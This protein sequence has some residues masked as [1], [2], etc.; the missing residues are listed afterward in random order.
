MPE[1]PPPLTGDRVGPYR[2]DGVLGVGGM[3]TVWRAVDENG[4]AVAL[5][6]LHPGRT[7][8]DEERRFKREFMTLRELRHPGVVAVFGAG[9][10]GLYPWL[11][12]E[13]VEGTD[14]D[15]LLSRWAETAPP[16]RF[17]RARALLRGLCEALDYVHQRGLIHRDIKPS[18]VLLDR[19]GRPKLTDFGVVKA[20]GGQFSTELTQVG[21]LVGTVAFMAPEQISGAPV[22]G[23][24]DLYSLGAVLYLLLTGRRPIEAETIAGYLSRHLTE[25]P[26]S[27]AELDPRVPRRLD[28]LCMRLLRK[29]PAQR[30]AS[31]RQVL[32]ALDGEEDSAPAALFGRQAELAA[33]MARLGRLRQGEGGLLLLRGPTGSGRTALLQTL[34][35]D[36]RRAGF[37]VSMANGGDRALL[38][39]L[40][41]QLPALGAAARG[42][43]AR[44]RLA[45]RSSG[46][47]WAL[48]IDDLDHVDQANLDELTLLVRLQLAIG[49]EPLLVIAALSD[50][51][52]RIARLCSGADTGVS[53]EHHPVN[54]LD[55]KACVAL[56]RAA[57]VSGQAAPALGHRLA[58]ERS[59]LPGAILEQ[60]ELLVRQG[61]L[62]RGPDG[63]LRAGRPLD[64]LRDEPL[65]LPER[66]R[67]G[68]AARLAQL[69][70]GARAVL[71]ALVVI[72]LPVDLPL[73]HEIARLPLAEVERGAQDLIAAALAERVTEEGQELLRLR[74]DRPRDLLYSLIPSGLHEALHRA[75]GEALLRRARRRPGPLGAVIARHLLRAG[76]AAE[77]YPLLLD[78]AAR[79]ARQGE[80]DPQRQLVRL[81]AEARPRAEASM[82]PA[83]V[84]TARK[85]LFRME[86]ELLHRSGDGEGA[87][88]AWQRCARAAADEGDA[89]ALLQ[90]RAGI[91]QLRAQAGELPAAAAELR[92]AV[93]GLTP[94]DPTWASAAAALV[95]VELALDD[96]PAAA[97]LIQQMRKIGAEP[98][99]GAV[100]AE[101]RAAEALRALAAGDLALGRVHLEEAELSLREPRRPA[102]LGQALLQ[103]AELDLA[104]G[105][106]AAAADRARDAA[107]VLAEVGGA[108]AEAAR[109]EGIGAL[110]GAWS[111]QPSQARGLAR[112][113]AG[114]LRARPLV[115]PG[116]W[117]AAAAVARALCAL[118][119]SEEALALLPAAADG[120]LVGV[121]DPIGQVAALR[122][123]A[124]PDPGEAAAEAWAA[125]ARPPAPNPVAAALIALD[126]AAALVRAGDPAALDAADEALER[127]AH[128]A[129][130][131]LRL[132][133][134]HL[135]A[136]GEGARAAPSPALERLRAALA[137]QVH[138]PAALLRRWAHPAPTDG[139]GG[140]PITRAGA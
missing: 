59:G 81:A 18:N 92:A 54:G 66:V 70:G 120:G 103:L 137:E 61:W 84:T 5:K 85:R 14:L 19:E 17:E 22:D 53:P 89:D 7:D 133:A 31:A 140:P 99:M 65:P 51:G 46:R 69:P 67:S 97:V 57:G 98:G 126:A 111:G 127:T 132:P 21:R 39:A 73:L 50:P 44:E 13:L 128:P 94:G 109:A 23:R 29:D 122:A 12:M 62:L 30:F 75:A 35:E 113:A 116:A 110:V 42:G 135:C 82:P 37:G 10:E 36:A 87:L 56:L 55:A 83:A 8:S 48:L 96:Q 3:A 72:D 117:L 129:L 108:H 86:A 40:C 47:P 100:A 6:V 91:G 88:D 27:P 95:R 16:D 123:R 76:A 25:D 1:A 131:G 114:A 26:R 121:D 93:A 136:E 32:R 106:W 49:G 52:G 45:L 2:L 68:E 34:A 33:L 119:L 60:L 115:G 64:D 28:Q 11:A 130:S 105:A 74:P 9:K 38:E 125:L 124:T 112:R 80:L 77:A 41:D 43:S 102:A 15:G 138:D 24:A 118:G 101:A 79:A 107:R 4:R 20:P 71:D 58:V 63:E 139:G 134:L 78:A 104:R 90:A